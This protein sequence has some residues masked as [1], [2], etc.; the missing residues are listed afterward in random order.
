MPYGIPAFAESYPRRPVGCRS[1][2]RWCT[3][4]LVSDQP[5]IVVLSGKDAYLRETARRRVVSRIV[6]EADPQLC[7]M[8][9][10]ADAELSTVFDEL[11]TL[12]FLAPH[13]VVIVHEAEAFI[14]AHRQA[15]ENY[16]DKPAGNGTLI[17]EAGSF[18]KNTRLAK[19]L[20][21]AGGEIIDCSSPSGANLLR[22]IRDAAGE[23]EIKLQAD[24]ANLL[25]EWV[26][27]DLASLS[28]EL[29]KLRCYVG[30]GGTV[31]ARNVADLAC[32]VAGPEAF[33][34]VNAIV[35]ADP[36]GALKTLNAA[37]SARGAEFALLGQLS[38]HVRRALQAAQA[39]R[40]G[41]PANAALKAAKVF[42]GQREFQTMLQR[43]GVRKLQQDARRLLAADLGMKSGLKPHQA[44]QQLVMELCT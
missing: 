24:A 7:V 35:A 29:D 4:S 30:A 33:A 39:I 13:R 22:W 36:A 17:L 16:L 3:L 11:R 21:Q 10:D 12:P 43:R 8:D 37:L 42:Y 28:T 6:G 5:S 38:W 26:G 20:P 44:M 15:L 34:L 27:E 32:N 19:K 14:T 9:F 18:P 41:T 2:G 25:A 31:T 23:R 40:A 1:R